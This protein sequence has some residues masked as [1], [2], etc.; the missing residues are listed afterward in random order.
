MRNT[1]VF[2]IPP[3]KVHYIGIG[4]VGMYSLARLSLLK[5]SE[6]SGSDI[7]SNVYTKSLSSMGVKIFNSHSEGNL[8]GVDEV[9]YSL[10]ISENNPELLYAKKN[11]I[12]TFTRA[13][14]MGKLMKPFK[15]RIGVS[16]S[17]G[18]S[19][20]TAMLYHIYKTLGFSPTVIAG[21]PI[22]GD[23]PFVS[24]GEDLLIY[25]A[26][27]YRDSF[28]KFSPSVV[29]V[30]NIE[31]DHTDYF[32]SL[33]DIKHSFLMCINRAERYAAINADDENTSSLL[34]LIDTPT[35][36][37]GTSERAALRAEI[38]SFL[39][40]GI[41]YTL[42]LNNIYSGE[43]TLSLDGG[44]NL[45]NALCAIATASGDGIPV[46]ESAR[47]LESFHGIARRME[48]IGSCLGK[49]IIYDYAHHP[50]EIRSVINALKLRYRSLTVIFKPHTYS[51][52]KDMWEDF[53]SAL[54]L[55]DNVIVTDIF[56]AREEPIAHI[57]SQRLADRIGECALYSEDCD[58]ADIALG[59]GG[60]AIVIMGAGNND[61]VLDA[62]RKKGLDKR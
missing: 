57:T 56:P 54:S 32:G 53:S 5:G 38:T 22:D 24:G 28:L 50:T 39:A 27:E 2:D 46:G 8:S 35:V 45:S 13:E 34:P 17:H 15:K 19:T 51:R 41:K 55:A 30:T 21:A 16:G 7:S 25:E 58:A 40:L 3:R 60:E 20:T 9:V 36:T 49:D 10:A 37:Y 6:V 43:Y 14:Y 52:T 12:P 44:F 1:Q 18:K 59:L 31:L 4:G 42:R 23:L 61:T 33:E 11:R 47:A 48:Y 62:M 29:A 26:C